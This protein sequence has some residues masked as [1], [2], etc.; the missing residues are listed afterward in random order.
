M[1][2]YAERILIARDEVIRALEAQLKSG[3][4]TRARG[5]QRVAD[6]LG[7]LWQEFEVRIF[8]K[9]PTRYGGGSNLRT[10]KN[11]SSR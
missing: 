9:L 3:D 1:P 11:N 6:F 8:P 10:G 7:G 2:D 5:E 4:Y